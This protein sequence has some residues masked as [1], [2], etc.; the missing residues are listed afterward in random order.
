TWLFAQWA[1]SKEV[2]V[3]TSYAFAG[4]YKRT[5]ANRASLWKDPKFLDLMSKFGHNYVEAST[6]SFAKDTDPDWRPRLPQ[7][8]AVG[9]TMATA[10]QSALVGQATPKEALAEA[11]KKIDQILKV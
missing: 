6:E 2:Q 9:D 10:I 4:A 1:G 5:G 8:P 3:A 11:Q 7:W